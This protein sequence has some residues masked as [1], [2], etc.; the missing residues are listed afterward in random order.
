MFYMTDSFY[1]ANNILNPQWIQTRKLVKCFKKRIS[2]NRFFGKV[3]GL[4][5]LGHAL[6]DAW[7]PRQDRHFLSPA[8][9]WLY[10][11]KLSKGIQFIHGDVS[12]A[13]RSPLLRRAGC[14]RVG[15]VPAASP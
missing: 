12:S 1:A 14:H 15:M 3:N 4:T 13:Q 7:F 11:L 10:A 9:H 2:P 6:L 5:W 8:G